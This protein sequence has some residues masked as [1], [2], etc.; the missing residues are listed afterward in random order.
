MRLVRGRVFGVSRAELLRWAAGVFF[1]WVIVV[2]GCREREL[3]RTTPQMGIKPEFW[4]RV[5]L[6][7]DVKTCVL[8]VS[9]SL[10]ILD[11]EA[12][13]TVPMYRGGQ[14]G[15]PTAVEISAGKITIGGRIFSGGEVII[16]PDA[17]HIFNVNGDDY[18]GKLKLI[19]NSD[20]SS[21]DAVN[22]V[23]VE[24]YLAGVVGAEMPD[25]WE[26]SALR[27]QAIAARTYCLYIKKRFGSKRGW[28]V[29]RTAANQVYLGVKAESAQTW[30]AINQTHGEVLVCRQSGGTEEIFP[31]YYSSTCGGHTE[32]SKHV[33]GDSF[34]PLVGVRCPYCRD[35]A[36]PSFFFWPTAQFD[37]TEVTGRL[38]EKYPKLKASGEITNITSVKQSSYGDFSRLTL[39]KLVGSAGKSNFLRAEDLRLTIDPSGNRLKSTIC[40]IINI[41]D[42]WA[43]LAG[44]GYGHGVGMCQCGAQ[45]MAR[46]GKTTNEILSYYYPGSKIIRVY[47]D[48]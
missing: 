13:R 27:A 19:L 36:K 42:K 38:L 34:E 21:F 25:Y 47:R 7:D 11:V 30:K 44:R 18:R 22:L 45:G 33:F 29:K 1:L 23:P 39:V 26:P 17:P 16:W 48:E 28:D 5:L 4:V 10:A 43:F 35:V 41:D 2:G 3:A 46:K 15:V 12:N 6:L 24:P 40:Q 20:G 9:S 14:V 31:T 37:K 32:D 8:K